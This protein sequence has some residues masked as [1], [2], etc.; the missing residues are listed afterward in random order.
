MLDKKYYTNGQMVY[1]LAGNRL[2]YY[3]KNR[4][5]KAEGPFENDSMEGEWTF[6]RETGQL[7]QVGNFKNGMKHGL[8]TR[9]DRND[10][11]EYKEEFTENKIVKK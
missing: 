4:K 9:W 8:F 6:Y 10:K 3:F 7:W 1:D 2:T 5:V 11:I